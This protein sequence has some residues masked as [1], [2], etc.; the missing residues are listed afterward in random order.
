[1]GRRRVLVLGGTGMLGSMV[2]EVLAEAPDLEV[3][4]TARTP[5]QARAGAARVPAAGW[6]V[7]DLEADDAPLD[8]AG[9][10]WVVSCVGLIKPHIREEEPAT[11]GRAVR[12][13]ALL[14][15]RLAEAARAGEARLLTIATDCVWSGSR[16]AYLETDP[17]D[18]L[19][20]YGKT[21]SLGEVRAEGVHHLRCSIVGPEVGRRTSLL[22]WFLGQ[23]RGASVAGFTDHRWNGVTSLAFARLVLGVVRRGPALPH[24]QHVLPADAVTKEQLL[25][26]FA[27]A[28]GREDVSIR[29]G[30]GPSPIDR[31]L[32]SVDPARSAALWSAA[33]E[34]APPRIE[35]LVEAL[36]RRRRGR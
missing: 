32:A 2:T 5:A 16:G 30:P 12:L 4:A 22:E 35:E 29:P 20:V 18:A 14:P 28:F 15:L 3:L 27:R 17:H 24:V 11:V 8:L 1:M 36:A 26:L 31:T 7:V 19:D 33:G 34:P 9:V 25:R 13:N 6:R 10:A 23:P 21:K